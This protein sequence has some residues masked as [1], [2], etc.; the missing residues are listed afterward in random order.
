MIF[1]LLLSLIVAVPAMAL[2]DLNVKGAG[3]LFPIA[4]PQLCQA[5]GQSSAAKEVAEV[6]SRDL[7]LSGIFEVL[8]SAS[9]I[10]QPGK[11]GQDFAYSDW[12]VIGSEGLVK[13]EIVT[14]GDQI[15]IKLYLHDVQRRQVVLG[16]EY[17]GEASFARQIAHK[18]ANEILKYFTGKAGV[19]GS[20]IIF[21]TK[22]GRFKE[23]S[24][25][26][27]DGSNLRQLTELRS[28]SMSASWSPDGKR[29]VFSSFLNRTPD[30][31]LLNLGSKRIEQ[32]TRDTSM[33]LGA[34]FDRDGESILASRSSGADS[35][36]VMLNLDGKVQGKLT[37]SNYAIDVSP[38]WS[39]D[40]SKVAFCSNRGGGP[41]IY[42]MNRDGSEVKRISFV[43]S[44]YCTSPAWSPVENKIA[45]VCRADA[46]FQIFVVN[47]D[48]SDPVQLTSV[49]NNEDPSWSP[50]GRYI[51]FASGRSIFSINIMLSD[52]S[53][54]TQITSGKISDTQPSWGPVP[55]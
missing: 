27:M 39:A 38:T 37:S 33:E 6:I 22:I 21:S 49:N 31:F 5:L 16:K 46:G 19:F 26:D 55:F 1:R 15:S 2:T 47:A 9:Y 3:K 41:Q 53:N 13:G 52:G 48:G 20:Q 10:E 29:V 54:I 14:R 11:C 25:V 32:I 30:L 12:S 23:L 44:N 43:T 18:F 17:N 8:N 36:L 24:I 7:Y 50:D 35:D 42:T 51:A 34:K 40:H 45:F 4:V 28:L